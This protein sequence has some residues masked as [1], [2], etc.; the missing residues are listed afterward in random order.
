MG[1]ILR[2]RNWAARAS[3][4]P[5]RR[6][7]DGRLPCKVRHK[8]IHGQVLTIHVLVHHLPHSRLHSVGVNVAVVLMVE[9]GSSKYH[10]E[11]TAVV[12][13]VVPGVVFSVPSMKSSR[14][15]H[16]SLSVLAPHT[17]SK[18]Y[19]VVPKVGIIV[20]REHG[21]SLNLRKG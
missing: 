8:E 18:D 19:L 3:E 14:E 17:E 16:K 13:V 7:F 9:G 2:K 20:Y 15:T 10:A 21:F 1:I 6:D 4:R 11:L 12:A 5:T